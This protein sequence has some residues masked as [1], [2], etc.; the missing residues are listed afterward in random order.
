MGSWVLLGLGVLSRRAAIVGEAIPITGDPGY[1]EHQM[2]GK[3]TNSVNV[4]AEK[5]FEIGLGRDN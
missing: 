3:R 1:H 2:I 4:V 5:M